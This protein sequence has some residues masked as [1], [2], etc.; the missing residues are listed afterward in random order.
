MSMPAEL[1]TE[2]VTLKELLDGIVDAPA[3]PVAGI[4]TDSRIL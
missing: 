1:M 3:I 4:A 2:I